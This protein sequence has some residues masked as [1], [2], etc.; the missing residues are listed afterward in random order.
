MIPK[1]IHYCW[2]GRQQLPEEAIKCINSWKKYCPDYEIKEWNEDNFNLNC[3]KFVK[4]AYEKKKWAF[5]SDYV[6]FWILYNEGG[7][8]FDTDVEIIRP[9][10]TI[11]EN[12]SFMGC[13]A[14]DPK[15]YNGRIGINPG[16]GIATESGNIIYKEILDFY[17]NK[18]FIKQNG[19]LDLTTV[20]KYTTDIL[21]IHGWRENEI[22]QTIQDITIYPTD[23]FCPMNYQTGEINITSNTYSIHHYTAS[24]LNNKEKKVNKIERKYIKKYGEKYGKQIGRII[25]FP[26]RIINK[27]ECLGVC[28]TVKFF[29]EQLKNNRKY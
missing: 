10:D 22:I 25:N 4:Q 3:C 14:V 29:L 21:K 11:I 13:E 26:Y 12:G 27:L 8:Y 15:S 23:Y 24:W 28:G 6:R 1:I 20:V 5:V 16:L 9:I 18:T 17:N 19:E 7:I 2:F